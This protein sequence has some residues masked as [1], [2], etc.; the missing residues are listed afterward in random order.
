MISEFIYI[1]NILTILISISNRKK[2]SNNKET[3]TI[4]QFDSVCIYK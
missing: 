1:F 3:K 2:K 4:K